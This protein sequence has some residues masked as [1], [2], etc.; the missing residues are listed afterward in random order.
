M[1]PAIKNCGDGDL[2]FFLCHM[3]PIR[4]SARTCLQGEEYLPIE[5][6]SLA[7]QMTVLH[8]S[9]AANDPVVIQAVVQNTDT[10]AW[11]GVIK[12]DYSFASA[13]PRFFLPGFYME[14]IGETRRC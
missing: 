2:W 6:T 1:Q 13:E 12:L 3:I 4:C 11:Q 9:G 8:G 14:Q 7:T 10:V 5:Q